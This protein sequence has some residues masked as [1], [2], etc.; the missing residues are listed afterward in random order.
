MKN[1]KAKF[2]A[3][4]IENSD[5]QILHEMRKNLTESLDRIDKVMKR[6]GKT[7]NKHKQINNQNSCNNY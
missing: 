4:K 3:D 6:L 7:L 2:L 5:E 1:N